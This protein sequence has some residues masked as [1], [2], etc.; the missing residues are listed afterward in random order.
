MAAMTAPPPPPLGGDAEATFA[1]QLY[2]REVAS[3]AAGRAD[4]QDRER[5]SRVWDALGSAAASRTANLRT[6]DADAEVQA[7]LSHRTASSRPPLPRAGGDG[8]SGWRHLNGG[9]V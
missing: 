9:Q 3:W 4:Q 8:G 6:A 7:L 1:R 2:A 5:F